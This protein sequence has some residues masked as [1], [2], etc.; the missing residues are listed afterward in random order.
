MS[1]E[2]QLFKVRESRTI[3]LSKKIKSRQFVS[4]P[5]NLSHRISQLLACQKRCDNCVDF[6]NISGKHPY[7]MMH[8]H[9]Q[10]ILPKTK[11]R[12]SQ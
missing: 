3:P 10:N 7:E 4:V 11:H 12:H 1:H 6:N 9:T 8:L 5:F 2:F